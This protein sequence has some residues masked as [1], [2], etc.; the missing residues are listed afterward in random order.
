MAFCPHIDING[1]LSCPNNVAGN[2]SQKDQSKNRIPPQAPNENRNHCPDGPDWGRSL[3]MGRM[4][5]LQKVTNWTGTDTPCLLGKELHWT[6]GGDHASK[7][8]PPPP[9]STTIKFFS[10]SHA[11]SSESSKRIRSSGSPSRFT[12]RYTER[13]LAVCR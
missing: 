12:V 6:W 5:M 8:R 2:K 10:W 4:A 3:G 1:C 9:H 11:T 7:F 13:A